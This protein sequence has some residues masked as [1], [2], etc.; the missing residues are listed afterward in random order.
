DQWLPVM[1]PLVAPLRKLFS[2]AKAQ[3]LTAGQLLD[4]LA[5]HLPDMNADPLAESL[6]RVAMAARLAGDAGIDNE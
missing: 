4:R 1:D 3:G 2:D 5:E 6:S